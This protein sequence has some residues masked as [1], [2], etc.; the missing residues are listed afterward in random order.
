MVLSFL[1]LDDDYTA[2]V[3]ALETTGALNVLS[4][5]YILT[6]DNQDASILVGEEFP[7]ITNTRVTD[8]GTTINTIQYRDIGIILNVTPHINEDGLVVLNISQELSTVTDSTVQ[9][10]ENLNATRVAKRTAMTRIAVN[11]GRTV[12]IGGL[13][14]DQLVSTVS[15][16]PFFGD[17]PVLGELF[18]RTQET[19]A[20]TELVL[21]LTPEVVMDP[22]DLAGV[23]RNVIDNEMENVKTTIEPGALQRHLD[24]MHARNRSQH[25]PADD[26]SEDGPDLA[27]PTDERTTAAETDRSTH[28][29]RPHEPHRQ[30]SA[31]SA[32]RRAAGGRMRRRRLHDHGRGTAARGRDVAGRRAAA[33]G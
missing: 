31:S 20:K 30:I 19:K 7:F 29:S 25:E 13:M 26:K 28:D 3:H 14:Q 9:I 6:G 22:A 32:L 8:E 2:A 10:S 24:R 12:V 11:D 15:K 17:I 23:T 4:R 18:K 1:V 16:V 33:T 27:G 5:P 21:F